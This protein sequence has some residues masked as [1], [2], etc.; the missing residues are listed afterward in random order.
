MFHSRLDRISIYYL[1][2]EKDSEKARLLSPTIPL[3]PEYS[4]QLILGKQ[5]Y[6]LIV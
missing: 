2:L 3:T 1:S 4:E 5:K 6:F